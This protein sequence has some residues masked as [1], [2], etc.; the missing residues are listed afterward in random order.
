[1]LTSNTESASQFYWSKADFTIKYIKGNV[2]ARQLADAMSRRNSVQPLVEHEVK[3]E[4][5][6]ITI[7]K[8]LIKEG[9]TDERMPNKF[10]R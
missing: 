2:N 3:E 4:D 7:I 9:K 5:K 8:S 6:A 1:M 10:T